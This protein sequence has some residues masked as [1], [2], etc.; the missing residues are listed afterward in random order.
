MTIR[1][2]EVRPGVWEVDIH[3]ERPDGSRKRSR[4]YTTLSTDD[5]RNRWARKRER[6]LSLGTDTK[7][8][9]IPT[10]AAFTDRYF[11]NWISAKHHKITGVS[12]R[13]R[14]M[15]LH[16]L[17]VLGSTK[18]NDITEEHI[19]EV[20]TSMNGAMPATINSALSTLRAVLRVAVRWRV[21]SAMPCMIDMVSN[22]RTERPFY[23]REDYDRLVQ[24]AERIGWR[25]HLVVLLGGRAGLRRGEILGLQWVDINRDRET[26]AV[27]RQ[28]N[29]GRASAPKGGH[30]RTVPIMPDLLAALDRYRHLNEWV[31]AWDNGRH[32]CEDSIKRLADSAARSAQLPAGIH[33]LRH[34]FVSHLVV[35]GV[36]PR[37]IQELAGHR[38]MATTMGYM[39]LSP[40]ATRDGIAALDRWARGD[41][42]ETGENRTDNGR[43]DND[44]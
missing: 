22:P 2:R 44:L 36:P 13:R 37:T 38:S 30:E 12:T 34:T 24:A 43:K 20:V 5:A 31:L 26:I 19:A 33:I 7:R 42:T 40:A 41:M 18:L 35:A 8:P 9:E 1:I 28:L 21:V 11:D 39:H 14:A 6:E 3:A 27:R 25:A 29:N 17:P 23:E 15:R 32:L 10:L 4:T 16:V